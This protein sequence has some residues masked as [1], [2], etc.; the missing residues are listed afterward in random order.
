MALVA[1]MVGVL[2]AV[3][4]LGV[5]SFSLRM[6]QSLQET[7]YAQYASDAA[8]EYIVWRLEHDASFRAAVSAAGATGVDATMPGTING[9][10]GTAHVARAARSF[11]YALYGGSETCNSVMEWTGAH[12]RLIG[13]AHSN[14]GIRIQGADTVITGTVTYVTEGPASSQ[15]TYYPGPPDNPVQTFPQPLPVLYRLSDYSDPTAEGTP[16]YRAQQAGRYH[17]IEGDWQINESGT[18]FDGLYYV[19]GSIKIN[20]NNMTGEATFVSR[21]TIEIVGSGFTLRPYV[22]GLSFYAAGE[23]TGSDRCNLPLI[24]VSGSGV[25]T[26]DG[27]FY[28][29]Y[30]K[31]KVSGSGSMSGAFVGDSIDLA[32]S[33]LTVVLP[34]PTQGGGDCD[35]YDILASA[36]DT[37]TYVRLSRCASQGAEILAWTVGYEGE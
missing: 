36:G 14:R 2:V 27:Y 3:P 23:Y 31:I 32:G 20:G 33:G 29:P 37:D 1:L 18:V 34:P 13:N 15:I 26:F 7:T 4:V 10:I 12:N 21:Q 9:L 8:A 28:A 35:V 25:C 17:Y 11:P 22:D 24:K 5:V 6:G 19:T 30:G 16:A